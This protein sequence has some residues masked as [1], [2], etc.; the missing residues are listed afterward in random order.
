MYNLLFILSIC[1]AKKIWGYIFANVNAPHVSCWCFSYVLTHTAVHTVEES[2]VKVP[3]HGITFLYKDFKLST[4]ILL[5]LPKDLTFKTVWC[6]DCP[7]HPTKKQK[8][9]KDKKITHTHSAGCMRSRLLTC[10]GGKVAG[11]LVYCIFISEMW[12]QKHHLQSATLSLQGFKQRRYSSF[13]TWV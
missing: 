8:K 7:D 9:K 6:H 12:N 4:G 5:G 13:D 3:L 10:F 11:F 1:K 2:K